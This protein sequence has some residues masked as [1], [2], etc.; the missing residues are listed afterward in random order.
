MR[1]LVDRQFMIAIEAKRVFWVTDLQVMMLEA[2]ER[3]R[4]TRQTV[5][6]SRHK[7]LGAICQTLIK[8][9]NR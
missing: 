6:T 7:P 1:Q 8:N 3:G 4:E 5:I 9:R 2:L